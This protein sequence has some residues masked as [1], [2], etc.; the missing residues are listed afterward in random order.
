VDTLPFL[1]LL[2][3]GAF[4]LGALPFSY[5]IGKLFLREDIRDFCHDRNPGAANVFRAGGRKS[6]A[7]AVFLDIAKGVPFVS[8]AQIAGY[9]LIAVYF[10]GLLA[11]LGH[12]YSPLLKFKGGKATAVTTG[13]LLATPYKDVLLI[14]LILIFLCFL[15]SESDG[16]RIVVTLTG[17]LVYTL[18][19]SKGI[20]TSIFIAG[21]LIILA[22][23][24][25]EG[26]RSRPKYRSLIKF[27]F[28]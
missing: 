7:L 27:R 4:A 22:T 23:K 12:A 24:N 16:W 6:C 3:I 13:V 9:P 26:L 8:L 20:E 10:I 1:I 11:I 15:I 18:F 2:S 5:W 21:I 28:G 14:T 17:V 19:A 25:L